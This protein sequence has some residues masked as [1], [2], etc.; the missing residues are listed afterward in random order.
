MVAMAGMTRDEML[1][2]LRELRAFCFKDDADVSALDAALAELS[3]EQPSPAS[4][5]STEA[6]I[7]DHAFEGCPRAC[8]R[9]HHSGGDCGEPRERHVPAPQPAKEQD[10]DDEGPIDAADAALA[11]LSREQPSASAANCWTRT[12]ECDLCYQP[13]LWRHPAGGLRCADCPRLAA[14]APQPA[15]E[16]DSPDYRP[17]ELEAF[18]GR[19]FERVNRPPAKE[20]QGQERCPC[21][22]SNGIAKKE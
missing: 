10:A 19:G 22:G 1:A 9:C 14:P 7:T 3:R 15:K 18:A 2:G 13:A 8:G 5:E 6:V 17:P 11:E 21:G 20:T 4:Q 16:Q 12:E